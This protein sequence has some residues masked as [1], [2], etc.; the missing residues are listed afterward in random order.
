MK[1]HRRTKSRGKAGQKTSL[2]IASRFPLFHSSGDDDP[3]FILDD[4]Y[5][6]QQ[7]PLASVASLRRLITRTR[8]TDHDQPGILD[9]LPRNPQR[10]LYMH[11]GKPPSQLPGRP[12]RR[13]V[14]LNVQTAV[15]VLNEVQFSEFMTKLTR[16]ALSRSFPPLFPAIPSGAFFEAG[17]ACRSER[18][19]EGCGTAVS[20]WS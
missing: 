3:I 11:T 13:Y 8:N 2:E 15:V 7:N 17:L 10:P 16:G 20:R 5:H 1:N 19:V 9:H 14:H 4:H 12:P 18:A 6:F